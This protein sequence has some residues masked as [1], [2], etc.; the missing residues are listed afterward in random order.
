MFTQS[1]Y[2]GDIGMQNAVQAVGRSIALRWEVLERMKSI[3]QE[4]IQT[5]KAGEYLIYFSEFD[6]LDDYIVCPHRK[7]IIRVLLAALICVG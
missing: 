1:L 4:L 6:T 5:L 2:I 7:L 3:T